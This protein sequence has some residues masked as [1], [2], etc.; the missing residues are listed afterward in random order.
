MGL[1]GEALM[2]K[3]FLELVE[4]GEKKNLKRLHYNLNLT[5][6]LVYF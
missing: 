3:M 5:Q 2:T 4:E 6:F 1:E